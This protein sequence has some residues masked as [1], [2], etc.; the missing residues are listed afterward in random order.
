MQNTTYNITNVGD[1]IRLSLVGLWTRF[2]YF[3]PQ[4]IGAIILLVVGIIVGSILGSIVRGILRAV[5]TDEFLGRTGILSKTRM[6]KWSFSGAIG[7][8]VK[9]FIIIAF[10]IPAADALGLPQISD[11]LNQVLL[12]IPNVIA[13]T[14]ILVIG[15]YAADFLSR[16]VGGFLASS[17]L[18]VKHQRLLADVAK[19]ALIVFACLAALVQLKVVPQLIEILFGG[20]VLAIALAFGLGGKDHASDLIKGIREDASPNNSDRV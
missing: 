12:Y 16:L 20:L 19:Y 4:L 1:S 5:H 8:I 10:L 9:W 2:L 6:N 7:S 15:L 14:V 11:F 17:R 3:I 13:A 18:S